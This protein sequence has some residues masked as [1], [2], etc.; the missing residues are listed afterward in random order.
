MLQKPGIGNAFIGTSKECILH[1]LNVIIEYCYKK[2]HTRVID[3]CL[4]EFSEQMLGAVLRHSLRG[5]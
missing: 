3:P 5:F 1:T 4:L 2:V